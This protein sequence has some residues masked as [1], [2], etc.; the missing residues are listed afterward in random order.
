M[1]ARAVKLNRAARAKLD[2][3]AKERRTARLNAVALFSRIA[4]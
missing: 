3:F 2:V 4:F 1:P